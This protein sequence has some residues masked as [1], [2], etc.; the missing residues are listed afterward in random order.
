MTF[1]LS[2][3]L[4]ALVGSMFMVITF[5]SLDE[6]PALF[7]DESSAAT[8]RRNVIAFLEKITNLL[9]GLMANLVPKRAAGSVPYNCPCLDEPDYGEY[10]VPVTFEELPPLNITKDL[11]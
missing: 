8:H 2:F 11:K 7:R 9:E 1:K 10:L 4:L 5:F 3:I 6:T